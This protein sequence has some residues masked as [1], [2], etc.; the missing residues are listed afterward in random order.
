VGPIDSPKEGSFHGGEL[1][2]G[3][4]AA[5]GTGIAFVVDAEVCCGA[6]A[7]A[8]AAAL[9]AVLSAFYSPCVGKAAVAQTQQWQSVNVL[10]LGRCPS[11]QPP[12]AAFS[13]SR[14]PQPKT[15]LWLC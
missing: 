14:C 2:G 13:T 10:R 12:A 9:A 15:V 4:G 5:G 7:V 11:C 8:V 3:G 1:A 6:V